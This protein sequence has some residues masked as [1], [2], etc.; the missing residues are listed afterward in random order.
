MK[1]R[2]EYL[3]FKTPERRAFINITPD[4]ARIVSGSGV[5]E[6]ICL[7]NAIHISASVFV[8]DDESGLHQDF[9]NWLE[10][11]APYAPE[12]YLNNKTG[13]D[14]A[15]THLKR[16]VIGREAVI[17]ITGGRLDFGPWEQVISLV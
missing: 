1:F 4:V 14:N 6:G 8:N 9:E 11:L 2:T 7:V 10:K 16:Q 13:E 3:T 5:K 17:A 15:D 12:S